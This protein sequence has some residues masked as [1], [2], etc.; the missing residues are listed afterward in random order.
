MLGYIHSLGLGIAANLHDADGI[1]SFEAMYPQMAAANGIDPST[2]ATVQFRISDRTY[3]QSLHDIVLGAVAQS[4]TQ[5]GFDFWWTDFQQGLPG[6]QDISGITPTLLLNHYRFRNHSQPGSTVRGNLHSRYGGLGD[7]RYPS[8]FGGDV[9]ET[10]NSLQFMV[11]FTVTAAN[12]LVGYWGHETMRNGGS[13]TDQAELYTRLIQFSSFSPTLTFWGNSAENDD[14][15][16]IT[17]PFFNASLLALTDR[18]QFLPYRYSLAKVAYDTAVSQLRPM[19]Y[20]HPASP[21]AYA[22][23]QQYYLGP[24]V[25]VAPVYVQADPNTGLAPTSVWIPP[26]TT[27]VYFNN[28]ALVYSGGEYGTW[29]SLFFPLAEVPVFVRA[30][31]VLPLSP[32]AE[33][34][35]FGAASREYASLQF[36]WYPG[37]TPAGAVLP[38]VASSGGGWVYEDDGISNDYLASVFANTSCTYAVTPA[39]GSGGSNTCAAFT[40]STAGTYP[41]F[42]ATR[43]YSVWMVGV[44]A[45]VSVTADGQSLPQGSGDGVPGTWWVDTAAARSGGSALRVYMAPASTAQAHTVTACWA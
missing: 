35:A 23:P 16:N 28:P 8:Q 22:A 6:I 2:N 3:A 43:A 17:Q 5:E 39:G 20:H 30:G 19:Y 44:P 33:A 27:F 9:Q 37:W 13:P 31:A 41:S 25:L 1:G 40:I 11:E 14:L 7:H 34:A 15:W 4:A 12:V 42:P 21:D 36:V 29:E 18:A 24:D 38:T 32:F 26:G 45:P 10:W